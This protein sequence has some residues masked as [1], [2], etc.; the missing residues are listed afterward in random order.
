MDYVFRS[1]DFV[2]TS[3]GF[4]DFRKSSLDENIDKAEER[5]SGLIAL[6]GALHELAETDE[7]KAALLN[8]A[9]SAAP[10]R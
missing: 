3:T 10:P 2:Y 9:T 8:C 5:S 1:T 4:T 7:Q 6:N